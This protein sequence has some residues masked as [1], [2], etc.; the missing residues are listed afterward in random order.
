MNP[1]NKTWNSGVWAK[2]LQTISE[3]KVKGVNCTEKVI[4]RAKFILKNRREGGKVPPPVKGIGFFPFEEDLRYH[5]LET[6]VVINAGTPLSFFANPYV[7]D[8]LNGLNPRHRPVYR[9]KLTKLLR[10]VSDT[11]QQEVSLLMP[12]S[13]KITTSSLAFNL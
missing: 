11:L 5:I 13:L 10:C 12:T 3:N 6:F 2:K 7:K 1:G 4:A 8:L 9:K